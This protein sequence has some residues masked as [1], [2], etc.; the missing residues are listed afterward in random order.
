MADVFKTAQVCCPRRN[1]RLQWFIWLRTL[2]LIM[3][4]LRRICAAVGNRHVKF[5]S[6][7]ATV[8][9]PVEHTKAIFGVDSV[10]LTDVDGS[11]SGRKEFI[12]WNTPYQDPKHPT[13]GRGNSLREAAK[14]ICQLILRGVRVIAFARIRDS[15][16]R[17]ISEV[18]T[19]LLN[20]ERPEVVERVMAYRGGYTPQDR[21]AIKKRT[22]SKADLWES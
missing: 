20:L 17:L 3:R 11:P 12:C 5:I 18:K 1:P 16:E 21:R 19:E 2:L 9:N 13:S 10:K 8:K 15:C 7:S 4:R 14:L 22:C 6:C